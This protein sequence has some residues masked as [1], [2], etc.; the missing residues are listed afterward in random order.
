MGIFDVFTGNAAKDAANSTRDFLNT[1]RVRG[2]SDINAGESA[3]TGYLTS[4]TDAARAALS[5][6]R[7][8]LGQGTQGALGRL[9]QA[10]GAYAPLSALGS[11]Y[12][13]A[14]TLGLNAL[15]VNGQ[16]GIDA[17]TGAFR[18]S[19]G[20][21][22]ALDQGLE[23][24]NRGRNARGMLNSG[25]TDRDA[26]KFGMGLADQNYQTWLTNLLGFTN[27][28]LGATGGAATGIAGANTNAANV[29]NQ[30]GINLANLDTRLAGLEQGAGQSL[31]DLA[32]NAAA[33][34]AGVEQSVMQPYANTYGQEAAAVQQG[35]GNLWNF[36]LNAATLAAGMPKFG[37]G[38]TGVADAFK[39]GTV[40]GQGAAGTWIPPDTVT[41]GIG[42]R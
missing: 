34:R 14:T 31:A 35:S 24:I 4:G 6:G 39:P 32:Q 42:S 17:A 9:D 33:R 2:L 30:G 1:S 25:N 15:G 3:A 40:F 12:G 13:A 22:F 5:A 27:P 36:G 29:L 38:G 41:G 7:T 26:Q 23:A 10:A 16:P 8:D 20:Y 21:N 37:G 28:E 11:K 18:A 19:P